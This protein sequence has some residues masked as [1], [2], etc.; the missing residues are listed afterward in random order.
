MRS[1]VSLCAFFPGFEA[2][3]AEFF[4]QQATVDAEDTGGFGFIAAGIGEGS[5]DQ[6]LLQQFDILLP[7]AMQG[8]EICPAFGVG[9]LLI[10]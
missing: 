4:V 9:V 8:N 5:L 1:E 7:A 2:I 10:V 3:L 6:A